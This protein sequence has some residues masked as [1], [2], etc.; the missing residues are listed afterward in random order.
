MTDPPKPLKKLKP[1]K[2]LKPLDQFGICEAVFAAEREAKLMTQNE[3]LATL[4]KKLTAGN[5]SLITTMPTK[6][7]VERVKK[8]VQKERITKDEKKRQHRLKII[9]KEIDRGGATVNVKTCFSGTTDLRVSADV[10]EEIRI[11]LIND[12]EVAS[13]RAEESA[14]KRGSRTI[15]LTDVI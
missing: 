14:V 3:R 12:L 6:E 1:P 5:T 13:R 2:G 4:N 11:R 9:Q 15:Q 10:L 7:H 8:A